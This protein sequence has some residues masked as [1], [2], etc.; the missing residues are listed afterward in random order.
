M[1]TPNGCRT[2]G[3]AARDR[4]YVAGPEVIDLEKL[5]VKSAVVKGT[6][7]QLDMAVP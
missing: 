4:S 5:S 2:P 1:Y 7:V 6:A 3:T